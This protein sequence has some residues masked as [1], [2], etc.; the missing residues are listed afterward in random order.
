MKNRWPVILLCL[1]LTLCLCPAAGAGVFVPDEHLLNDL[2]DFINNRSS[3]SEWGMS[4]WFNTTVDSADVDELSFQQAFKK[5]WGNNITPSLVT[6]LSGSQVKF[7]SRSGYTSQSGTIVRP[8]VYLY[9][10]G[11]KG[12]NLLAM[13]YSWHYTWAELKEL[14]GEEV[15]IM[16]EVS[17]LFEALTVVFTTTT[18]EEYTVVG[19]GGVDA[20]A[21]AGKRALVVSEDSRGV[22]ITLSVCLAN[23]QN[24][25][26][27]QV[28]QIIDGKLLVV[29][30]GT[31]DYSI[32]GTMWIVEKKAGG[33]G[34]ASSNS[35]GGGCSAGFGT[36][37]LAAGVFLC[38]RQW[39]RRSFSK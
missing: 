11:R 39:N 23:V 21:A 33:S 3:L 15:T 25:N 12:G 24:Q 6:S 4:L 34:T 14:L 9:V 19:A 38:L 22:S 30:D 1:T 10:P 37:G 36:L 16:P 31:A 32:D 29:P 13:S 17:R 35:G 20:A 5:A 27:N 26:K 7:E 18:G 2:N 8:G 28:P